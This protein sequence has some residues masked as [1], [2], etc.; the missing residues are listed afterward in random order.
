MSLV[1][2]IALVGLVATGCSS[3]ATSTRGSDRITTKTIQAQPFAKLDIKSP[4]V[5]RVSFG[6]TEKIEVRVNENLAGRLVA[7]VSGETL[8][9][10]LSE[11]TAVTHATLEADVTVTALSEIRA[12][13]AAHIQLT[14]DLRSPD[15]LISLSGASQLAGRIATDRGRVD[16]SGASVA[17]LDGAASSLTVAAAGA[18][19]LEGATFT[20]GS[21]TIELS[22][23]S[24]AAL[25]VTDT[26]SAR[27]SDASTLRYHGSPRF[28]QR[29]VS[30]A[31]VIVPV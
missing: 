9:L 23:A 30:G 12:L 17:R 21:L 14:N 4:F 31:S 8:T 27:L 13:G 5:V 2:G 10:G 7:R 22:T 29:A 19:A 3:K 28:L 15:L 1:I 16:L 20:V 26:I 24:V 6:S 11:G 18:S 25:T